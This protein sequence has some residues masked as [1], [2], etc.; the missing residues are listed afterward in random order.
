MAGDGF[1]A[2]A[3]AF[4]TIATISNARAEIKIGVAT[5]L[6][7]LRRGWVNRCGLARIWRCRT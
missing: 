1:T 7:D 6:T 4:L 2:F 5:P 3:A